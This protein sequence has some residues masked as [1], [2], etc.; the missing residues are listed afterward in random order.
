MLIFLYLIYIRLN[1]VNRSNPLPRLNRFHGIILNKGKHLNLKLIQLH[2]II[3]KIRFIFHSYFI[4][5]ITL[6]NVKLNEDFH[7]MTWTNIKEATT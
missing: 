6:I 4:L 1:H 5:I 3:C 7:V 2:E